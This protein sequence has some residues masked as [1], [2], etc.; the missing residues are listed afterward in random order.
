MAF[1]LALTN[2]RDG[3]VASY[4][5]VTQLTLDA[6]HNVAH[7]HLDGFA[8]LGYRAI[9]DGLPLASRSYAITGAAFGGLAAEA[10]SGDTRWDDIAGALYRY[11]RAAPRPIPPGS[12]RAVTDDGWIDAET[13]VYIPDTAVVDGLIPSEF[14][15]AADA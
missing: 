1:L 14:R 7:V 10:P 13:G 4:W 11:I 3:A 6:R 2:R 12:A 8:S 5:R 15:E 9:A